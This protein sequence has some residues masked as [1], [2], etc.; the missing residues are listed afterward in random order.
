MARLFAHRALA[1]SSRLGL[2]GPAAANTA[3]CWLCGFALSA[4]AVLQSITV[5]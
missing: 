4:Y 1:L 2:T 3:L 5:A